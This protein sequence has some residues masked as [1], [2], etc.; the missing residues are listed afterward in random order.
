MTG[1]VTK[2][3]TNN[4]GN[5]VSLKIPNKEILSL[6]K[7]TVIQYFEESIDNEEINELM[8][9]LWDRNESQ[10]TKILSELL[11]RTISY[12]DYQENFYHAFLVGVFVT[13][14]YGIASNKE[15]GL[16]RPDIIIRDKKNRRAI[17]IEA[18]KS[19]KKSDMDK[20]A[21]KAINQIIDKDYAEGLEDYDHI[22]CYGISFFRKRAK[23]KL[24]KQ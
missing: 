14:A 24:M 1:Y 8:N 12:N 20:D 5:T 17:I 19:D 11:I 16:G 21:D 7:D 4:N 23:V 22:L 15:T 3:D 18:K 13:R 2:A 9:A 6:F 10:A